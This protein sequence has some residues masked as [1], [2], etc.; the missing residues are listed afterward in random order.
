M[1]IIFGKAPI[2]YDRELI[3]E[4]RKIK[5]DSKI[6]LI[7]NDFL[8]GVPTNFWKPGKKIIHINNPLQLPVAV[9]WKHLFQAKLIYS[10]HGVPKIRT[11]KLQ[12]GF[13]WTFLY[14]TIYLSWKT[15]H[16][17]I[18]H[19]IS[20]SDYIKW[21]L[22]YIWKKKSTRIYYGIRKK[23]F[24][25]A[26][27][28]ILAKKKISSKEKIILFVGRFTP[29]KDPLTFIEALGILKD[30]MDFEAI[31]INGFKKAPLLKEIKTKIQMENLTDKI[32][33]IKG[34][35]PHK[36]LKEYY[37]GSDVMVLPSICEAFGT[38]SSECIACGT[39]VIVSNLGGPKDVVN[40][41]GIP[42]KIG[43]AR[44]LFKKLEHFL[45]N[46]EI[47]SKLKSEAIKRALFLGDWD[48]AA[49]EVLKIY[50]EI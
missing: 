13:F 14:T 12:K 7:H 34:R 45:L 28:F 24:Y 27:N 21:E 37:Q 20:C 22:D 11:I 39:P 3:K 50:E 5:P 17:Q 9:L 4:F 10:L 18:D 48:R 49:L 2:G 32:K 1:N 26:K 44:D 41:G 30:K 36:I 6:K 25:P 8:L 23:K 35:L 43:N 29:Y 33:V 31:M 46:E 19:I 40:G 15:F 16:D 38:V 42:F 47:Q